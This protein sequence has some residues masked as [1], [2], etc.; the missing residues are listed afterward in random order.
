MWEPVLPI[1]EQDADI[2]LSWR[3]AS[4]DGERVL[5]HDGGTVGQISKLRLLPDRD[6]AVCLLTN[7]ANG[8]A[9]A[10]R[11]LPEVFSDLFGISMPQLP[12]P[13]PTVEVAGLER[14]TGRYSR[15]GIDYDVEPVDGGL[16]VTIRPHFGIGGFDE[17]ETVTMLPVDATGNRFAGRS[18]PAEAW[19]RIAFA[20]LPDGRAQLFASGR[21]APMA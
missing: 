2:G 7:S 9:L 3:V 12:L 18:D 16:S 4:W 14:H 6:A 1:P 10:E 20:T 21:V 19:W 15:R 17:A 5:A 11:L 8:E 13:D